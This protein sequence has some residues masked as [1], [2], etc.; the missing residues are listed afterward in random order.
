MICLMLVTH[1]TQF[2]FFATH[3]LICLANHG[4]VPGEITEKIREE[5]LSE[6]CALCRLA[7]TCSWHGRCG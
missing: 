7:P 4:S 5:K 3:R 2:L 1:L 6:L